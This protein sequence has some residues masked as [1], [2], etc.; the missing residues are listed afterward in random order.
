MD[1][2]AAAFRAAIRDEVTRQLAELQP[3]APAAPVVVTI[4]PESIG[5]PDDLL[6]VRE[7]AAYTK[8]HPETIGNA[9]RGGELRGFQPK[10]NAPWRIRREDLDT[11]LGV[12]P[13]VRR[14]PLRAL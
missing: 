12:K 10:K 6:T 1:D 3:P 4:A 7:A 5:S 11:W 8:R 9:C 13:V 14:G 2:L